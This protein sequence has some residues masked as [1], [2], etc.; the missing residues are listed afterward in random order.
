MT[1]LLILAFF[2]LGLSQLIYAENTAANSKP[3]IIL[4]LVDDAGI[5]D[6]GFSGGKEFPTPNIDRLA[7]E[8]CVFSSAYV[9]PMCSPTR[10][11]LLTG[12]YTQRFGIEDNRPL[13]GNLTGMDLKEV[14]L[15]Q[16]LKEVGYHTRLIG[17][18]HLGEGKE[19]EFKP[20]NRGFDEFYGY[21]GAAGRYVNPIMDRNGQLEP[22]HGY[23]TDLLTDETCKFLRQQHT[24]PFFLH[25][26]YMAVH[27][28]QEAQQKDLDR[29][30]HLS[31]KRQTCAAILT[32]LDDNIG[33]ILT[34]LKET[35]LDEKTLLFFISDNGGEPSILGSTNGPHR[36]EKFS[37]H[38]GGIHIPF[39]MRWP[40]TIPAGSKYDGMVHGF[41]LFTTSLTAAG[42]SVG[43]GTVIDG[44][45]LLPHAL[46][47]NTNPAHENLC[48]LVG[49]HKEWRIVGRD[50]NLARKFKAIREGNLKLIQQGDSP[51]EL[52]DLSQDPA[53]AANLAAQKPEKV[54]DLIQKYEKWR[55]QMKPQI[56]PEDHPIYGPDALAAK[57]IK[58]NKK[59]GKKVT[60]FAPPNSAS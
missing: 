54:A 9:N 24:Q 50:T 23:N 52:Y 38:E 2:T 51:P 13:D 18:W 6:F 22:T 44:V 16:K 40:G 57:S 42:G 20:T 27:F 28:P 30:S 56:I 45:D 58:K 53:E 35:Q 21:Y 43:T 19:G 47:K 39:A 7:S 15:P 34:T 41:D 36:G 17:K 46:G 8:G 55:G 32:N 26:A 3:N 49:D 11:A 10:A 59:K 33:R 31:G 37:V 14:L 12:R 5:G 60:S 4:V 29:V 1:R 25:L 48:W